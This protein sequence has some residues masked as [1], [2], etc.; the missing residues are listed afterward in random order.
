ML[1][2][3]GDLNGWVEGRQLMGLEFKEKIILEEG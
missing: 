2:M 1:C 3:L